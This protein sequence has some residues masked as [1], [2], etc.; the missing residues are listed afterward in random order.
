MMTFDHGFWSYFF[1]RKRKKFVKF[2]VLGSMAPDLSYFVAFFYLGS[3]RGVLTPTLFFDL[4][5]LVLSGFSF[6]MSNESLNHL[7]QF[8]LDMFQNEMVDMLRMGAHSLF[9]WGLVMGVILWKKGGQLSSLKA[10]LWG[11]GSHI[12][13]DLF[14]HVT[15]AIPIFFPIS[16]II[17]RGPIS[18]WNPD[19][20]GRE[21]YTINIAFMII[22]VIYLLYEV[23]KN[24]KK[25]QPK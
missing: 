2:F 13:V 10:F 6:D 17:I 3:Q 14:T 18:Y 7:H 12:V 9:I 25:D 1:F 19:Y 24:C 23:W 21:F 20:H 16:D 4:L 5:K 11:W 15:D 22:A 8:I